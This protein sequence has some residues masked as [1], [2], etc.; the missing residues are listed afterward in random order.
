MNPTGH[1]VLFPR[2][3]EYEANSYYGDKEQVQDNPLQ[4]QRL[5]VGIPVLCTRLT[6]ASLLSE[7]ELHSEPESSHRANMYL[8]KRWVGVVA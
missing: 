2:P 5:D 1:L 8:K 3:T 6:P 4:A 7:S